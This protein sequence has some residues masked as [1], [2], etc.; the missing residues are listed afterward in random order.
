[1][2]NFNAKAFMSTICLQKSIYKDEHEKSKNIFLAFNN[3]IE[4]LKE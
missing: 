1:M 2:Y 3:T 4:D